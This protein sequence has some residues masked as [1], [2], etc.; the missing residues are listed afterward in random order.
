[1]FDQLIALLE[2]KMQLFWRR[3]RGIDALV[4][5]LHF[6]FILLL[7]LLGCGIGIGLY[8]LC[9]NELPAKPGIPF[10]VVADVCVLCFL[11][12]WGWG[13]LME[14]QRA[15]LV[16]FRKMLYLP[17]SMRMVYLL[18]YFASLL[19][20]LLFF[21]CPIL[22]GI[23]LGL[24][25]RLG[26]RMLLILPFTLLFYLAIGAWSYYVQGI[27]AVLMEN[28][29]RRRTIITIVS[30]FTML[31]PQLMNFF[32]VFTSGSHSQIE[33]FAEQHFHDSILV[34]LNMGI[35]VGWLPY[36]IYALTIQAY[37]IFLLCYLA[38]FLMV[39][40]GLAMGLRSTWRCYTADGGRN[41]IH[42]KKVLPRQ[43]RTS[44]RT[45]TEQKIPF[46]NEEISSVAIAGLLTYIRHP[47]V[48]MML[49][50]PFIFM[51]I[52]GGVLWSKDL[53]HSPMNSPKMLLATF[54]PFFTL[55]PLMFNVFGVDPNGF[56][57]YLLLPTDRRS[58]LAG[59]NLASFPFV[60]LISV[61]NL[62]AAFFFL[63]AI[64]LKDVMVILLQIPMVFLLF[65][66]IGNFISIVSP[67][68]I[69]P[70]GMQQKRMNGRRFLIGLLTLPL[71]GLVLI[72][73]WFCVLIDA[74][75]SH[76]WKHETISVGIFLSLMA[77]AMALGLYRYSL[78]LS[79]KLMRR[80]E[81]NIL[82]TFQ[83]DRE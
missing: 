46:V 11:W 33:Q 1:M 79:G 65:C 78:M 80:K 48:R 50:T 21:I 68:R 76:W 56:R 30:V 52:F 7:F 10:L 69:M 66:T 43:K 83:Y 40:L 54:F 72:P 3:F 41:E 36:G 19:T 37:P 31:L 63:G 77:L 8:F 23:T 49:V 82:E 2:V 4:S 26:A 18:N 61:F 38:I 28:K 64:S 55:S 73:S 24:T 60:T 47:Q 51:L 5:G 32:N 34:I 29:R 12:A 71:I 22:L 14:I 58:V 70:Y 75:V 20:P 9:L 42:Q 15:D 59:M 81:Q 6:L 62:F 53:G 67:Y 25:A 17:I 74:F 39:V 13:L 57:L 44:G 27:V 35:P 16:D 45:W